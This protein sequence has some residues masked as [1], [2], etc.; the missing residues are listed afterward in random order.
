MLTEL[1]E[2]PSCIECGLSA[3][4]LV[5]VVFHNTTRFAQHF[6]HVKRNRGIQL[7][8]EAGNE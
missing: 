3:T 4:G 2:N 7:V 1:A 5:G 8:D 6:Y